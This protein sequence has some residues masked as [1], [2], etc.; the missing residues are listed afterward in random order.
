MADGD[1]I[2]LDDNGSL[3]RELGLVLRPDDDRQGVVDD[4]AALERELKLVMQ[5][6]KPKPLVYRQRSNELLDKARLVQENSNLKRSL[7]LTNCD[8]VGYVEQLHQI[9]TCVPGAAQMTG[10]KVRRISK[11]ANVLS[12]T[13]CETLIRASFLRPE[14][15]ICGVK[16]R[17]LRLFVE[18]LVFE[19]QDQGIDR[20]LAGLTWFK[21]QDIRNAVAVSVSHQCDSTTQPIGNYISEIV[22]KLNRTVKAEVFVQGGKLQITC[23]EEDGSFTSCKATLRTSA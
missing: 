11:N 7:A 23:V 2:G 18:S 8:N 10:V 5:A 4:N 1:N 13:R 9:T 16:I 19:D 6:T 21:Q 17:R 20:I 22:G 3:E 12:E 14:G 15:V